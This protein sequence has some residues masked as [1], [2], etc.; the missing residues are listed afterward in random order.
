[1]VWRCVLRKD[2]LQMFKKLHWAL[3][4]LS[5]LNNMPKLVAENGLGL[6]RTEKSID[7]DRKYSWILAQQKGLIRFFV[8]KCYVRQT[9]SSEILLL[10]FCQ[11]IIGT[12]YQ[13]DILVGCEA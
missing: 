7:K 4:L 6:K 9:Q 12:G 3:S 1:M 2:M 8:A 13:F 10:L 11:R 5:K